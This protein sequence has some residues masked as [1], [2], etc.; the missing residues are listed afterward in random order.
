MNELQKLLK[1]EAF[2]KKKD[3]KKPA[4]QKKKINKKKI[5]DSSEEDEDFHLSVSDEGCSDNE[6]ECAE[7]FE[8]YDN[9]KSTSDWIRCM[10]CN[11]WLHESC[12]IFP[13]MC[14]VCGKLT[15]KA[16]RRQNK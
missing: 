14:R 4:K 11:R 7:C 8:D 1:K 5:E 9:T 3:D 10:K 2:D 12:T 6:N 13:N 15:E 16:K